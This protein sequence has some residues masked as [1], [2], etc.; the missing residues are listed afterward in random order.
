[1]YIARDDVGYPERLNELD[2]APDGVWATSA[3]SHEGP[4]VAIVG[5]RR[6]SEAGRQVARQLAYE[7]ASRGALVVSG[8]ALGI[9]GEAHRG[10]LDAGGPTWVVL[11]TSLERPHPVVHRRLFERVAASDGGVLLSELGPD[12]DVEKSAFRER[13]RII[14]ALADVTVV[15]EARARSGTRYTVDAALRLGR[16]LW[17]VPWAL[18]DARFDGARY[19]LSRG[20]NVVTSPSALAEAVGCEGPRRMDDRTLGGLEDQILSALR[21]GPQTVEAIT[22]ATES[23]LPV[24]LSALTRLEVGGFV[25][26]QG[27][28]FSA[29]LPSG[30]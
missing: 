16:P 26:G 7:L 12:A 18:D 29:A 9:D 8:G 23:D 30:A 22:R 24:V 6:A 21:E 28:R 20:A 19:A 1:M 25:K 5:A 27:G 17:V 4:R 2:D 15:V 14:A 13:N 11:P 3:P 10:A